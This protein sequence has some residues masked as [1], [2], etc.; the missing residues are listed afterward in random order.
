MGME[1]DCGY[2]G[3]VFGVNRNR[4]GHG[5]ATVRGKNVVVIE[6][7]VRNCPTDKAIPNDSMAIHWNWQKENLQVPTAGLSTLVVYYTIGSGYLSVSPY[8]WLGHQQKP[9]FRI[10]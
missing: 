3:Q 1:K 8:S 10:W 2:R 9:P 7:K 6:N 4:P 5:P